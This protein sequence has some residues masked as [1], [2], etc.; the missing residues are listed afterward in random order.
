MNR[1][2]RNEIEQSLSDSIRKTPIRVERSSL[3]LPTK[4]SHRQ[5]RVIGGN[6][7]GVSRQVPKRNYAG[8]IIAAC[9]VLFS[10]LIFVIPEF[11]NKIPKITQNQ[12]TTPANDL[13]NQNIEK[14]A[15]ETPN[16]NGENSFTLSDDRNRAADY[17]QTELLQKKLLEL[18]TKAEASIVKGDF[19]SPINDNALIYYQEMLALDSN[20]IA[21]T[22]GINYML[23]RLLTVGN[24]M[25]IANDVTTAKKAQESL[26]TIDIESVEYFDL[27]EAISAYEVKQKQQV[28]NQKITVLFK[29]ADQA[30]K[31]NNLVKPN[32]RNATFFYQEILKLDQKNLSLI[33]I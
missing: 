7:D 8:W 31:K 11:T 22:D 21:A 30:A 10:G 26:A 14:I 25:L 12:S 2:S 5:S 4:D 1:P 15:E 19:T 17:R 23:N 33:H 20:N 16:G 13:Y 24:E 28:I 9:L 32:K 29:Q 18:K 3:D 6:L 27:T